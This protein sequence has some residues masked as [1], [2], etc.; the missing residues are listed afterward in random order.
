M[1]L[2]EL[3]TSTRRALTEADAAVS[4]WPD[5][6]LDAWL[7]D[8]YVE[9]VSRAE[10]L[11]CESTASSKKEVGAYAQAIDTIRILRVYYEG[12][13]EKLA[14]RTLEELDLEDPG[15]PTRVCSAGG[16]P[17]RW[18]ARAQLI[19]LVPQPAENGKVIKMWAIQAP[20]AFSGEGG[21]PEIS[22][23]YH[24][25]LPIGAAIR[26]L[27][28][29]R[30]NPDNARPI[31]DLQGAFDRLVLQA[32]TQGQGKS[33]VKKLRDIRDFYATSSGWRT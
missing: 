22:I 8:A 26:A 1:N 16:T 29:D 32:Y 19:H 6:D 10:L 2:A 13:D 11:Q 4:F 15:W 30:T 20:A 7:Y 9:F 23:A 31:R 17:T 28:A 33:P 12:R 27:R 18:A 5:V 24:E 14:P 3:R 25:A 21:S